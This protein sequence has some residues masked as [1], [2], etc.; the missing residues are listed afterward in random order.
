MLLAPREY[1]K[2]L[3]SLTQAQ[4]EA[5]LAR[6]DLGELVAAEPAAGG[7]FGQNIFVTSSRGDFVLR[8]CP[9]ADWQLPKER[10]FAQL[11]HTRSRLPVPW[12]YLVERS[13]EI[14]G[15][16]FAILPRLPGVSV[17]QPGV[18]ETLSAGERADIA[19][20]LGVGLADL[21]DLVW[22]LPGEFD[23]ARDEILSID[24]SFENRI[25][26][27]LREQLARCRVASDATTDEDIAWAEMLIARSR[28]A[29]R[30][31]FSPTIVHADYTEGNVL[32]DRDASGWRVSGV[33]D[34]MT[35]YVGDPEEDLVRILAHYI[36]V[37][38]E[39]ARRLRAAYHAR[40]PRRPGFAERLPLYALHDAATLWEYG[41]RNRI[42]FRDGQCLRE[43]AERFIA[44]LAD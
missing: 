2:R 19:A 38:P 20:A 18:S 8:G 33:L 5:A 14:F 12:P 32:V 30:G 6:F 23:F 7:L 15:W 40:H 17:A 29:L 43:F 34:W 9:H 27:R 10:F 4:L 36:R 22:T 21:H 39:A 26:G 3:G 42:W 35:A 16:S 24:G 37:D 28:E 41:Q 25:V 1:S 44:R 13:P 11:L 31:N